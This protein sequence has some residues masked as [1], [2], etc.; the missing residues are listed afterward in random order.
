MVKIP[1]TMK[2]VVVY[3]PQDYR[4]EERP[5][6]SIGPGEVLVKILATGICAS[7]V[8]TFYGFRVWGSEDI[9]PYIET[10][11][12]PGHEFIGEVVAL[13]EGAGEKFGIEIG[14]HAIAEQIV[15]CGKCMHCRNGRYWLC[16]RHDIFGFKKGRAE[17]SWAQYMK[18]PAGAI[19]HK[20]PKDIKPEI[21][22]TVEPLACAI[23]A[24]ERAR[25]ELGDVVVIGGMGPIGLFMLQ[26]AKLKTPDVLIAIDPKPNRL[27]VAKELGADITMNP[28]EVDVV[29]EVLKLTNQYGCDIYIEASGAGESIKQGLRMV[30]K[31]G[32]VVI[33]G[34]YPG[35]TSVDWSVV[36]DVKELNIYGA[37][38]GPYA[39]PKAIKYLKEGK[40]K[41][42]PIVTHKFSLEDYMKGIEM[43]HEGKESIKVILL[44]NG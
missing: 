32:T 21:A 35:P 34:V 23:H 3:G 27:K 33:F 41:A 37:H 39:Y 7:D 38:L 5:V 15:P 30:R 16:E 31:G 40:I 13:G 36:G 20:V 24:V 1:K 26:I 10:P 43:V 22:A 29:K 19:V 6:P 17:G 8:K 25:I 18:Y 2:A 4:L 14:D 9:P 44:P 12:I 28:S 42:E 11:V